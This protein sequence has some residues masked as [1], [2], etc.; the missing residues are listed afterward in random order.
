MTDEQSVKLKD[1]SFSSSHFL[2]HK[3]LCGTLQVISVIISVVAGN[4]ANGF[5]F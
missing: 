1:L 4:G 3:L 5:N 2:P